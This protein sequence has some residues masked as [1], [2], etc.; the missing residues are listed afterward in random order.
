MSRDKLNRISTALSVT[1]LI[2]YSINAAFMTSPISPAQ[3]GMEMM[4]DQQ[5]P[6]NV[7]FSSWICFALSLYLCIRHVEVFL[8][9]A[10]QRVVT[11]TA[12]DMVFIMSAATKKQNNHKRASS[13]NSGSTLQSEFSRSTTPPTSQYS[14]EEID[15][16]MDEQDA[17]D[18]LTAM[19]DSQSEDGPMVFLPLAGMGTYTSDIDDDASYPSVTRSYLPQYGQLQQHR[20]PSSQHQ[21]NQGR[22]PHKPR[23]VNPSGQ[24]SVQSFHTARS[25]S[26]A[27][28]P[29]VDDAANKMKEDP[30]GAS[31]A[32]SLVG[33]IDTKLQAKNSSSGSSDRSRRSSRSSSGKSR[34]GIATNDARRNQNPEGNHSQRIARSFHNDEQQL[35]A[36]KE[37]NQRITKDSIYVETV[38]SSESGSEWTPSSATNPLD[39]P[40]RPGPRAIPQQQQHQVRGRD[41]SFVAPRPQRLES[42]IDVRKDVKRSS[43]AASVSPT[44][45]GSRATSSKSKSSNSKSTRSSGD[46]KRRSKSRDR[47]SGG[48]GH[49]D[50]RTKGR[51]SIPG[52]YSMRSFAHTANTG[53]QGGPPTMSNSSGPR[54]P[55]TMSA[56]EDSTED[57]SSAERTN[58][59]PMVAPRMGH[60]GPREIPPLRSPSTQ[61]GGDTRPVKTIDGAWPDNMSVVSEPTMDGF[62]PPEDYD[63]SSR[64]HHAP[65]SRTT[66]DFRGS[67]QA[68]AGEGLW[69]SNA[70][71]NSNSPASSQTNENKALRQGA[72][73]KMVMEA[74][75]QAQETRQVSTHPDL[76][77]RRMN[78]NTNL[79]LTPGRGGKQGSQTSR[80]NS[81]LSS[82]DSKS[83]YNKKPSMSL[84]VDKKSRKATASGSGGRNGNSVRNVPGGSIHS[85]YS[86]SEAEGFDTGDAFAC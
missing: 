65:I 37:E 7:Y 6:A 75:R 66:S 42:L 70:D 71:R 14:D 34:R 4:S 51:P 12:S 59:V 80:G 77:P 25:R 46:K 45:D 9:P 11:N 44:I 16:A 84:R 57:Y 56:S 26:P 69:Y 83:P 52:G 41:P 64:I 21:N 39:R 2:F 24:H 28:P 40:T 18:A 10:S 23:P 76:G 82:H 48:G 85:F 62:G 8:V 32:S 38:H 60:L 78:Q 61:S 13:R 35:L 31:M 30:Y 22:E 58:E 47:D 67:S 79:P 72:V 55:L 54:G 74:L 63:H 27:E 1:S 43:N 29:A 73:D 50:N 5:P 15:T 49:G 36:E 3:Q 68:I 53:S 17:D 19:V 86:K 20:I 81:R 33:G